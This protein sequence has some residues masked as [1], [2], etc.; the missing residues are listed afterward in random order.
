MPPQF[1]TSR[2]VD[3]TDTAEKPDISSTS[4]R[5]E[6]LDTNFFSSTGTNTTTGSGTSESDDQT[7]SEGAQQQSYTET[8]QFRRRRPLPPH[9]KALQQNMLNELGQIQVVLE[10]RRVQTMMQNKLQKERAEQERKQQQQQNN[11]NR[12]TTTDTPQHLDSSFLAN[13]IS[14]ISQRLKTTSDTI[15]VVSPPGTPMHE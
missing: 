14:T 11:Q 8:H 3:V 6:E 15:E 5:K 4:H 2:I 13:R 10:N 7:A 1:S 12:Q 9:L